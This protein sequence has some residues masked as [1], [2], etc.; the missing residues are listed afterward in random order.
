MLKITAQ[1]CLC[2]TLF[3]NMLSSTHSRK[4]HYISLELKSSCA[5]KYPKITFH[6]LQEGISFKS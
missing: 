6:V 3:I 5:K 1:N 4:G 2:R